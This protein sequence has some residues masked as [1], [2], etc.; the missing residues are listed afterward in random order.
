ML[1]E[2]KSNRLKDYDYVTVSE[3][4]LNELKKVTEEESYSDAI[5]DIMDDK[6]FPSYTSWVAVWD[7]SNFSVYY[8]TY[9]NPNIYKVAFDEIQLNK[10]KTVRYPMKQKPVYQNVSKEMK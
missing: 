7:I 8:R 3:K 2:A 10:N 6:Q 4:K 5:I 9:D 1:K